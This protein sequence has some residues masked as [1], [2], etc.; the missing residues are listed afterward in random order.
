MKTNEKS[1][2]AP[3]LWT[4]II[5]VRCLDCAHHL[6]GMNIPDTIWHI[7]ATQSGSLLEATVQKNDGT[8][9]LSEAVPSK[10]K[11]MRALKNNANPTGPRGRGMRNVP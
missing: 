7:L 3:S 10:C 5:F 4:L 6:L 1:V 8:I 11:E 9:T 2:Y